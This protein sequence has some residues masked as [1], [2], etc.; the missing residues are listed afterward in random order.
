MNKNIL[1][2]SC[3]LWIYAYGMNIYVLKKSFTFYNA[4]RK[5]ASEIQ[6]LIIYV[7]HKYACGSALV[8]FREITIY[9]H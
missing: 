2:L 6:R 5:R 8:L 4:K 7:A 3:D 9:E 1:F